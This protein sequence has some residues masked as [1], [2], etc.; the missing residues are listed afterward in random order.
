MPSS[1]LPA[2]SIGLFDSQS[3]HMVKYY[4]VVHIRVEG[5]GALDARCMWEAMQISRPPFDPRERVLPL[6]TALP[7]FA[8]AASADG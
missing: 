2:L 1:Y 5:T 4:I 7:L 3:A 8:D 6:P